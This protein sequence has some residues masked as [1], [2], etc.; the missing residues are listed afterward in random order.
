VLGGV[1]HLSFTNNAAAV[2]QSNAVAGTTGYTVQ[3]DVVSTFLNPVT[4][5]TVAPA[6]GSKVGSLVHVTDATIAAGTVYYYRVQSFTPNGTSAWS[7]VAQTAADVPVG[8]LEMAVDSVTST[9]NI[10]QNGKLYVRGWAAD[11]VDGSPLRNV[12]VYIDG[13]SIGA[14]TLGIARTDVATYFNNP[15]YGSSGYTL[16]YNVSTL[17]V[18]THKVTVIATNSGGASTTFGPLTI[19]IVRIPVGHLDMAV[20]SGTSS[21]TITERQTLYVAGWAADPVDGSPLSNLKVYIDG[22]SIGTPTL[23]IARAD[24]ATFYNNPAYLNSGFTITYPATTLS[25]GKHSVTAIATNSVGAST[26]LGPL[27]ITITD[28]M[29][30]LGHLDMAVD[31]VTATSSVSR[32]DSLYVAG[33]AADY[34]NNGSATRVRI[35]I[36]GT[37]VGNATLNV[38][39]PDVATSLNQPT[40]TNTGWTYVAS[41]STLSVGAH[42]VTA[43]AYDAAG[44]TTTLGPASITVH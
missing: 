21:T 31:S 35:L 26:T 32:A 30:P 43:V 44:N 40:W 12:R 39:R 14:P 42:T 19:T 36:D 17:T 13:V 27:T 15:A 33:W 9:P 20:D 25:A 8:Q 2:V 1:A 11:P 7:N 29:P 10:P 28:N 16:T 38:A 18:G 41:A 6:L 5:P 24:V 4:L 22:I 34:G 37:S 3:R 23:G